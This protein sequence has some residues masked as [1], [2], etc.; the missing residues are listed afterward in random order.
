M[1]D[2]LVVRP[3][4]ERQPAYRFRF[5][6]AYLVLAAIL[7]TAIGTGILLMGRSDEVAGPAWSPW[8]PAAAVPWPSTRM[9]P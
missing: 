9:A 4:T 3:P 7:G 6:I 1:A 5:G 2:D 8:E